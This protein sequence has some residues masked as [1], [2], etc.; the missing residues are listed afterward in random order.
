MHGKFLVLGVL[1][2]VVN[3]S[4]SFGQYE[5]GPEAGAKIGPFSVYAATGEFA[6]KT[7]DFVTERKDLPTVYLFVQNVHWS[8]PV[9]RFIRGLDAELEKGV[10]GATGI[11]AVGIWLADDPAPL[12]DHLPRVQMSIDL[13]KTALTVF[14]GPKAG[15]EGWSINDMAHLTVVIARKGKVVK[16]LGFESVNETNVAAVVDLIR[17]GS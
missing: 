5:S 12:K 7:V 14:E 3:A 13:K 8:R 4:P 17:S 10:E 11:A 9:A 16:S 6:E 15:P 2:L 1:F